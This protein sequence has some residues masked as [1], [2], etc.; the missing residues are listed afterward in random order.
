MLLS[1]V[2][3]RDRDLKKL[4]KIIFL[5]NFSAGKRKITL[6]HKKLRMNACKATEIAAEDKGGV[7]F[8]LN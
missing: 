8:G 4:L 6:I 7:I 3:F 5:L 2:L 1:R